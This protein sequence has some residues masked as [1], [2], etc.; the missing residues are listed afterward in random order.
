MDYPI[1]ASK[2]K[3]PIYPVREKQLDFHELGYTIPISTPARTEGANTGY[4]APAG[5]KGPIATLLLPPW[6]NV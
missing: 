6:W 5:F 2:L 4:E 1:L 3:L